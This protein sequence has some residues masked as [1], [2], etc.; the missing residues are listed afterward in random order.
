VSARNLS[1]ALQVCTSLGIT[2]HPDKCVPST[3]LVVLGIELDSI[4]QIARLPHDKL[5]K[6]LQ[7]IRT[8]VT[9]QWCLR[10]ELESLIGHLHHAAKVVWPG[11]A[12]LRRMIGLLCCFRHGNHPIR[13][14][15]EFHLDLKWWLQFLESWNGVSFW[16][17]PGMT[18]A[19]SMEVTSDAAGALGYGAFFN[20]EWFNGLWF[21]GQ[22]QLS[23]AY[24]EL[25]PVVVAAHVWGHHWFKQHVMFRSDNEA[26]VAILNSRTSKVPCIMHLLRSLLMAAAR[27]NFSFAAVHVPGVQ[28]PIADALSRFRWQDFR[29]LAPWALPSPTPI[30]R[31]LLE[32]LTSPL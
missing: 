30:P 8:W 26:V 16:L 19:A 22:I 23:I 7:L 20:Q 9:R 27:F 13:L 4:N 17:Y 12:F 18:A 10:R 6:L 25:F 2:L 32:E 3:N 14:N 21:K 24:K 1:I 28:N 5:S 15:V 31:H 29:Q 11:R